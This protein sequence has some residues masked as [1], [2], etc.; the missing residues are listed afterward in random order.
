[1]G[2]GIGQSCKCG[3]SKNATETEANI[4]LNP[5][6]IP[7]ITVHGS[8]NWAVLQIRMEQEIFPHST[9]ETEANIMLILNLIAFIFF[10]YTI[11]L[12]FRY[13]HEMNTPFW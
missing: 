1:M 3:E 7:F 10:N 12:P 2:A 9:T 13:R 8:R 5:N 6:L 4:M 11:I